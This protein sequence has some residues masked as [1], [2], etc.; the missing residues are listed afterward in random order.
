M[1]KLAV[2][3]LLVL[4]LGLPVT[5]ASAKKNTDSGPGCGLG[6][7]LWA[8]YKHPK[9]IAPQVMMFTT[10][11]VLLNT[12]SMSLGISGCTSDGVVMAERKVDVF[13][14]ANYESPSQ[15][16]ARG[17]GE[18]LTSLATLLGVPVAHREALFLLAKQ[19]YATLADPEPATSEAMLAVVRSAMATQ[20]LPSGASPAR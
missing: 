15:D 9:N 8:E 4:G 10:N 19:R 6:P 2:L 7:V 3:L 12:V 5:T 18:H 14:A 1:N 20:G 11:A 17:G 13:V 16:L